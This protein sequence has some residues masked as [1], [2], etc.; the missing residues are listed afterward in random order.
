MG[1]AYYNLGF[2]CIGVQ[3]GLAIVRARKEKPKTLVIELNNFTDETDFYS[4]LYS[5]G[6]PLWLKQR[7][8]IFR[9]EYQLLPVA[10]MLAKELLRKRNEETI[11]WHLPQKV[12][13]SDGLPVASSESEATSTLVSARLEMSE[14]N[15]QLPAD[16]LTEYGLRY[17]SGLCASG[18][19]SDITGPVIDRIRSLEDEVRSWGGRLVLAD[20]PE[21][22]GWYST[23]F[24]QTL[25]ARIKK[26]VNS[27]VYLTQEPGL[28]SLPDGI[29][30]A[31]SDAVVYTMTL[32]DQLLAK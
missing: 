6:P 29:H 24:R 30:L 3:G 4:Q 8:K 31:K 27:V 17:L 22:Q 21:V 1:P 11:F 26:E 18:R 14:R 25:R 2:P 23:P 20:L 19:C 13:R 10:K 28:Y 9:S 16:S 5:A 15:I 32:R 7:V 12:D